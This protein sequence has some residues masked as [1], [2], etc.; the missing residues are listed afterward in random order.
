MRVA[1]AANE[2]AR[3]AAEPV[4]PDK[5]VAVALREGGVA[6]A[7]LEQGAGLVREAW[8]AL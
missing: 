4:T 6:A 7:V 1:R 3:V 5:V 8:V 2:Q